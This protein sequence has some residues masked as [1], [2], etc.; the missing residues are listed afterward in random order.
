MGRVRRH[1]RPGF[2]RRGDRLASGDVRRRIP[3]RRPVLDGRGLR[4]PH[5][6]GPGVR[7]REDPRGPSRA[8]RSCYG[9]S[10][11][12]DAP[13]IA[14]GNSSGAVAKWSGS[15]LQI[16]YTSVRIRSAPPT[17]S[18]D[19]ALAGASPR[20]I[21]RLPSSIRGT[22]PWRTPPHPGRGVQIGVEA[23]AY[24]FAHSDAVRMGVWRRMRGVS[25][26]GSW[27]H[28]AVSRQSHGITAPVTMDR[29]PISRRYRA[30]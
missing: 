10:P 3:P 20:V 19:P 16:R 29:A 1:P 11:R 14:P 24:T 12:R 13:R 15:G 5:R 6:R 30:V 8:E 17:A 4:V 22:C 23:R 9:A 21:P 7:R 18:D 26:L 25:R 28:G 2:A 27:G